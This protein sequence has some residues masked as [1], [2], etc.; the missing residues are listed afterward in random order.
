M[1]SGL[2]IAAPQS[3]SGKTL[4]TLGLCRTLVRRGLKVAPAKTGPDYIDPAFLS[5]AAGQVAI[6]LDP[7]AMRPQRLGALLT[8]QAA[9]ADLAIIEGVMGLFDGAAGGGGS[10]ADLAELLGLPVVLVMDCSHMAQSVAAIAKGF[11][12]FRS[13]VPVAG[14]VLNRVASDRHE[15]ML[16]QSLEEVGIAVVGTLRRAADLQVPSRHLGLVL[17]GDL[18]EIDTMIEAA[19]DAVEQGLDVETLMRVAA[20]L[21]EA[22]NAPRLPPLG[23]HIAIASD[24]AFA[25]S[26]EHWLRDWRNAGAEVSFFSPLENQA[27]A[28]FADAVFLPG[29]Y[30]ELHGARLAQADVFHEGLAHSAGRDALIYGEC[31]GYMVLGQSLTDA[32]G[33]THAMSGLLPHSTSID[34]PNRT[35]GYRYLRH[36]GPLPFARTLTGHEFHYSSETNRTAQQL[37]VSTDSGGSRP[38]PLGQVVGKVCGS[39]AHIIDVGA[40]A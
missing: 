20:P 4:V 2:I 38:Q 13:E 22:G 17:P 37:F 25:F 34:R 1:A 39:Y 19:A 11:V 26:Y 32:D 36:Q 21:P 23:Q 14:V 10:T 5:R 29:G 24:A 33:I 8:K 31:G 28:P 6:N 27:P 16:R 15:K 3:G 7:F 40:P 9:G 12:N 18:Q 35:L 30:P